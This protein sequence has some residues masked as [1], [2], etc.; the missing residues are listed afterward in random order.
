MESQNIKVKIIEP[1]YIATNFYQR[2]AGD[3]AF[4]AALT[5]YDSFTEEMNSLF[6]S[7]GNSDIATPEDVAKAVYEAITD[8]TYTL[9]YVVGPDIG[10]MIAARDGKSE[11]EY[12]NF[13][14]NLFMPAAFK[15]RTKS[16]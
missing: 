14:R 6:S 13:L 4:D 9:R 11:Q 8:E 10:P 2:A 5:D 3:F 1:G 12:V 16:L 7:F 15:N